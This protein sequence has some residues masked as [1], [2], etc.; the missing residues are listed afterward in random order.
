MIKTLVSANL[1]PEQILAALKNID[2][3]AEIKKLAKSIHQQVVNSP[4]LLRAS[5]ILNSTNIQTGTMTLYCNESGNISLKAPDNAPASPH[6]YSVPGNSILFAINAESYC[7][8][9]YEMADDNLTP[10]AT[11]IIDAKNPLLIDGTK[12][13]YDSDP[14][15]NGHP[16]FRGSINFPDRSADIKVF[17]RESL[18]KIAWFPHDN[19]AARYLV[20]LGLLEAVKDPGTSKVAEEL[21][22][23]YHPAVAWKTFQILQESDPQTAQGYVP[24]LRKLQSIPLDRLLDQHLGEVA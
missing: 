18:R 24:Q 15:G 7:V 5:T 17:E 8:R 6:L 21:I 9:L 20:A 13:L 1:P 23:H 14:E 16:S 22:Y 11:I 10:G 3:T 12:F 4:E 2:L 19:S